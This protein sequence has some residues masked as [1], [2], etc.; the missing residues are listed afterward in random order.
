ME[1]VDPGVIFEI[2]KS[3]VIINFSIYIGKDVSRI[4]EIS[5]RIYAWHEK[6]LFLN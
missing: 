3:N 2:S 6:Y 5:I 1:S 4:H